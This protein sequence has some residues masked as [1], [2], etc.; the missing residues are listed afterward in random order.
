M[1]GTRESVI[2]AALLA[3]GCQ[4]T[5]LPRPE[6]AAA[7]RAPADYGIPTP[8]ATSS[9]VAIELRAGYIAERVR[10]AFEP[11][12]P[13]SATADEL[14]VPAGTPGAI[15]QGG[16]LVKAVEL[17]EE[18]AGGIRQEALE[19][20]RAGIAAAEAEPPA[21]VSLVF[22]HAYA[23]PPPTQAYDLAELRRILGG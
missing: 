2:A 22:D 21:D 11:P 6:C 19:V 16:V 1:R 23:D 5:T 17:T 12:L 15:P 8:P 7:R 10:S 14:A 13:E 20:M 9:S 4:A 18:A 3:A